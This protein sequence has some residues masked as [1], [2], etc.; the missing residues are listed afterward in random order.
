MRNS[1]KRAKTRKSVRCYVCTT[2]FEMLLHE[3]IKYYAIEKRHHVKEGD[4]LFF[5]E[6]IGLI[7]IDKGRTEIKQV[8]R[9]LNGEI[10][11]NDVLCT[12]VELK[13][14]EGLKVQYFKERVG[15]K[16]CQVQ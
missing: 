15:I 1:K 4:I 14:S 10:F 5:R 12:G 9:V 2:D 11:V 3:E 16:K 8:K 7:D 6:V 13:R